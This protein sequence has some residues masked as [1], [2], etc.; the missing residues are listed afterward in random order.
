MGPQ[1]H[2]PHRGVIRLRLKNICG[3]ASTESSTRRDSINTACLLHL[4]PPVFMEYSKAI[5]LPSLLLSPYEVLWFMQGW[6]TSLL[7]LP[8][9]NH[10]NI[11]LVMVSSN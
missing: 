6:T 4:T 3:D 8:E 7:G 1:A 9:P 10:H 11:W 2:T 5:M